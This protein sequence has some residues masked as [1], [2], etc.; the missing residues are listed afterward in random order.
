MII[1]CLNV[2]KETLPDLR[3]M[4]EISKQQQILKE[5]VD[6]HDT[7]ITRSEVLI[8]EMSTKLAKFQQLNDRMVTMEA[9][10]MDTEEVETIAQK[11]FKIKT[12]DFP[13]MDEV[14][15][16]QA[17]T[18]KKL[19]EVI[20]SQQDVTEEV[21]R[22]DDAKNSLIVYGVPENADNRSNQMKA[23]FTTIKE[24]YRNRVP[25]STNDLQ[26]VARAGPLKDNQ[27]RPIKIT[28][29]SMEKRLEVLRNN[30]N[31]ILYG[32]NECELDFCNEEEDHKHIYVSTDK[33]KKQREEEKKLRDELKRRKET[34]QDLIIRNGKIMKKAANHARWSEVAQDV[35]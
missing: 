30:K 32:E 11:C 33:T 23:D 29:T 2:C 19:E 8:E 20:K 34:E 27:I 5:K 7:R 3:N 1:S 14:R 13:T 25:I 17:V 31:L 9:K 22:R 28:F 26:Q 15:K 10:M 12:A 21:K 18:Q 6:D 4:L 16:D 24:L 35:V